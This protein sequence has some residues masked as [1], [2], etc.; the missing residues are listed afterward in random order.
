MFKY[1]REQML[2]GMLLHV[3]HEGISDQ[4]TRRSAP[5][6]ISSPFPVNFYMNLHTNSPSIGQGIEVLSEL[7][8]VKGC[9]IV[10]ESFLN[11]HWSLIP[12]L[13]RLQRQSSTI[14]RLAAALRKYNFI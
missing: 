9:Q 7:H 4:I 5:R 3:Y 12:I 11:G 10:P 1:R 8:D 2:A 14:A 13:A 6:T